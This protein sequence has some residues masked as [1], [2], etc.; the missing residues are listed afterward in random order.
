MGGVGGRCHDND[1]TL[2]RHGN[3]ASCHCVPSNVPLL[4]SM[5]VIL[6]T[7]TQS[8]IKEGFIGDIRKGYLT[9]ISHGYLAA[10][11][12]LWLYGCYG[13]I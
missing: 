5:R 4:V 10:I 11:L 8:D 6:Q 7:V 9:A 2:C 3:D 13:N 1:V 12:V